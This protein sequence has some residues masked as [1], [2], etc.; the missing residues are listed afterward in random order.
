MCTRDRVIVRVHDRHRPKCEPCSTAST[1]Y[2]KVKLY[3][4]GNEI[5]NFYDPVGWFSGNR[6]SV[7]ER[8]NLGAKLLAD[9]KRIRTFDALAYT[10][11]ETE[12]LSSYADFCRN[13]ASLREFLFLVTRFDRG[14][15]RMD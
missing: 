1:A 3:C 11:S 12:M 14:R 4:L 2:I 7:N 15:S 13:C 6:T 9:C 8:L 5:F 10:S